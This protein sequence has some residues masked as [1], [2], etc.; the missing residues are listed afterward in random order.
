MNKKI[1]ALNQK[2]IEEMEAEHAKMD[3]EAAENAQKAEE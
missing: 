3:A 2:N 1:E